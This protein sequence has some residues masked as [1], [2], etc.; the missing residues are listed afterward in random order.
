MGGLSATFLGC[1][2]CA[3]EQPSCSAQLSTASS[4]TV[5]P[6]LLLLYQVG[7]AAS[8]CRRRG[9]P[10]LTPTPPPCPTRCTAL[11]YTTRLTTRCTTLHYLYT[12]VED[13]ASLCG[14]K[15]ALQEE[16][17]RLLLQLEKEEAT[18]A[19]AAAATA[20]GSGGG[21]VQDQVAIAAAEAH[22]QQQG[23]DSLDAFM[24]G[25]RQ[26]LGG[27][28]GACLLCQAGAPKRARQGAAMLAP[29]VLA[30]GSMLWSPVRRPFGAPLDPPHPAKM[31]KQLELSW[32]A[33]RWL[34]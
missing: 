21:A 14:K 17:Q 6:A 23:Q 30:V 22:G 13:A 28:S 34:L 16:R 8:L 15:E 26:V 9:H 1:R 25:E 20:G 31:A 24:S 5:T 3:W 18:A 11:Y 12:Q 19:A 27:H 32:R 33:T 7:D 2:T 29:V 10:T 4:S